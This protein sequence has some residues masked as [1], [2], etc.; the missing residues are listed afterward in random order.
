MLFFKG[1]E[2]SGCDGVAAI[3]LVCYMVSPIE[4]APV[5]WSVSVL[6]CP[7]LSLFSLFFSPHS[8]FLSVSPPPLLPP[9]FAT[10]VYFL[11]VQLHSRDNWLREARVVRVSITVCEGNFTLVI[12]DAF[13]INMGCFCKVL[14]VGGRVKVREIHIQFAEVISDP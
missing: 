9:R 4:V 10:G 12:V 6:L 13:Y 8:V 1:M 14:H 7:S 3:K 2:V 11:C 5:C